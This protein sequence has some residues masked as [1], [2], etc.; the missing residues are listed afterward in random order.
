M[1]R[2]NSYHFRRP[3]PRLVQDIVGRSF[4][5][6]SLNTKNY[7]D[8]VIALGHAVVKT[9]YEIKA[10]KS[11]LKQT[12]KAIATKRECKQLVEYWFVKRNGER[13]EDDHRDL[14]T[15]SV[16]ELQ[17]AIRNIEIDLNHAQ[18]TSLWSGPERLTWAAK[19]VNKLIQEFKLTLPEDHEHFNMMCFE[20]LRAET[21]LLKRQLSRLCEGD[22]SDHAYD[23]QFANISGA[24]PHM[25][26]ETGEG[27]TLEELCEEYLKVKADKVAARTLRE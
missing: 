6:W 2:S 25:S 23:T 16:T 1:Q 5:K 21:E 26:S 13:S 14:Q 4:W 17:E 19:Q 12:K 7:D 22:F 18:D 20:I 8:A 24:L 11:Q 15:L 9:D 3:V 10:A 27:K